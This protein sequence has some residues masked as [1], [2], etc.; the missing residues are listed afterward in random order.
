[1]HWKGSLWITHFKQKNKIFYISPIQQIP[2]IRENEGKSLHV[3]IWGQFNILNLTW[4]Y[5][6]C[7]YKRKINFFGEGQIKQ[8]GQEKMGG[9]QFF[10]VFLYRNL[11]FSTKKLA[12][13]MINMSLP[14]VYFLQYQ[15]TSLSICV[16]G[17]TSCVRFS[18]STVWYQISQSLCT[19]NW[20]SF[21]PTI[22]ATLFN[23]S[24]YATYMYRQIKNFDTW[25]KTHK[26]SIHIYTI[27]LNYDQTKVKEIP[28]PYT[29]STQY[30]MTPGH[31]DLLRS[32]L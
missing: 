5:I 23:F 16:L 9:G 20:L 4:I 29:K 6:L 12:D 28:V 27:S 8:T 18:W 1:M 17:L 25:Q 31:L 32:G 10:G 30:S 7:K 15:M 24:N 19:G 13:N 22:Y 14:Q 3:L 26:A 21:H 2:Q 11:I